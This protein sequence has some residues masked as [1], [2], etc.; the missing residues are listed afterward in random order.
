MSEL[1]F[2]LLL[3]GIPGS[4]GVL[5]ARRRR[6]NPIL[7]GILCAIFPFFIVVLKVHHKPVIDPPPSVKG[8]RNA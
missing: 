8:P 7:W 5:L 6:K 1:I 2:L 3:F 4:I